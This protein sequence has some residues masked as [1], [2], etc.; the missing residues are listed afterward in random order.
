MKS[1]QFLIEAAYLV[2]N[3]FLRVRRKV[4]Y[5]NILSILKY[6]FVLII[7][8]KAC[9]LSFHKEHEPAACPACNGLMYTLKV[10]KIAFSLL[11]YSLSFAFK[12]LFDLL[13]IRLTK[14]FMYM[15]YLVLKAVL[16]ILPGLIHG[17]G[18]TY[19]HGELL[20]EILGIFTTFFKDL[21]F[22]AKYRIV[23]GLNKYCILVIYVISFTYLLKLLKLPAAGLSLV[24]KIIVV[25]YGTSYGSKIDAFIYRT[26]RVCYKASYIEVLTDTTGYCCL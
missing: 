20:D 7:A 12:V 22:I 16:L 10:I 5:F 3:L 24:T 23:K 8:V 19:I 18:L 1:G 17:L 13:C 21:L 6:L 11:I 9:I 15:T 4:L 14:L 26:Y 2:I 25:M